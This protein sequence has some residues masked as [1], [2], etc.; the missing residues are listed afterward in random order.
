MRYINANENIDKEVH[1]LF[2]FLGFDKLPQ[3]KKKDF[4]CNPSRGYLVD[5]V[6]G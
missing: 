3:Q 4:R 1:N 2:L 6:K 5:K